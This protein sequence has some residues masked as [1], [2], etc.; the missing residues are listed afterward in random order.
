MENNT[1]KL[2]EKKKRNT[3]QCYNFVVGGAARRASY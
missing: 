3:N 1:Q 2:K